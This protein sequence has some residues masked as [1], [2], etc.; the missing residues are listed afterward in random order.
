MTRDE[1]GRQ[2]S[3]V[4]DV[5]AVV[6]GLMRSTRPPREPGA[7]L[8][9]VDTVAP[10]PGG[11]I[12]DAG[13]FDGGWGERLRQRCR[14]A[15]VISVDIVGRHLPAGG[16]GTQS[17]IADV[18][19]MGL[20][21]GVV[22][23]IWCRDTISCVSSPA[24]VLQEF[25]RILRPGGGV[26][27]YAALTT[28]ELEPIEKR[29]LMRALDCPEWWS[30]GQAPVEDAI[31]QSGLVRVH[32]ERFSP[33]NQEF[34]MLN[35]GGDV[36]TDLAVLGRLRRERPR[37]ESVMGADWYERWHAWMAWPA[38]LLLGKLE[39]RAW[40]LR[41]P[42]QRRTLPGVSDQQVRP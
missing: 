7:L 40:V 3:E 8:E 9:L 17:M 29:R 14:P 27:L 11:V 37:F 19:R 41:K 1:I 16:S 10:R 6:K 18:A 21:N 22:D 33:E 31:R 24:S 5:A 42:A 36:A 28:P 34:A 23:M 35:G 32:E 2:F 25:S 38:Y 20:A 39:T 12:V 13:A 26:V 30:D 15:W 4:V